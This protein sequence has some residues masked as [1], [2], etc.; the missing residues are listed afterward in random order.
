MEIGAADVEA[1]ALRPREGATTARFTT[2]PASATT[3]TTPASTSGGDTS[4][5]TASTT[6]QIPK[7]ASVTPFAWA[8]RISAPP[9]PKVRPAAG[10]AGSEGDYDERQR[11]RRRVREH[12]T[13]VREERQRAGEI[14]GTPRP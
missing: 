3:P 13:G 1:L 7:G 8:A 9:R 6:I 5:R 2:M 4:R 10:R 12:V 11:K 14:P